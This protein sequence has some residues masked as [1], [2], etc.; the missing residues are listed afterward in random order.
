MAVG[1][2]IKRFPARVGASIPLRF[3]FLNAIKSVSG[4]TPQT[5]TG[6]SVT[7]TSQTPAV[8][9]FAAGSEGLVTSPQ[10]QADGYTDDA[11]VGRFDMLTPGVVTVFV[12][13]DAINPVATYVGIVQ[14]QVES[15]PTP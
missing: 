6:A 15:I 9:A 5:L 12:T 4:S 14:F 11:V 3:S 7:W 10:G 13:V 2:I 1:Q 8:A